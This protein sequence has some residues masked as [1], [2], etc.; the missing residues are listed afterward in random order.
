MGKSFIDLQG[1]MEII[2]DEARES[3][4]DG[5]GSQALIYD[6]Y[7]E[8]QKFI[9]A[10]PLSTMVLPEVSIDPE[11][12]ISFEW[13]ND[14]ENCFS[15]SFNGDEIIIYAGIFGINK[16]NGCEYFG[17]EIPEIIVENIKRV[18]S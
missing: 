8:A 10:F 2:L 18:Y 1:E 17:D 11:G 9:D 16:I 12:E 15:V 3:N 14:P 13:Y 6:S 5:Y 7:L 4:W